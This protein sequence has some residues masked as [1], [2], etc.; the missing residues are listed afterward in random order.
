MDK[1]KNYFYYYDDDND[2]SVIISNVNLSTVSDEND[3]V[4]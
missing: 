1:N 2:N 3:D 4:Y